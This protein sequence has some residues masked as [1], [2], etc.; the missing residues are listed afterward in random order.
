MRQI[1]RFQTIIFIFSCLIL[2]LSCGNEEIT[3]A[4]EEKPIARVNK[5][6][7]Y[8]SDLKNIVPPEA[9]KK[10]STQLIQNFIDKWIQDE[11]VLE[12]A[13]EN[14]TTEQLNI[15]KQIAE[16]RK[17]LIIYNF[18]TELVSQKLDTIITDKEIETYYNNNKNQF[19]LK[20]NIV[21][22]WYI[23]TK[24][25]TPNAEKVKKWYKS[26]SKKD[27]IA[28]KTF[29]VQSAENYFMDEDNWLLFDELLK[30]IPV[31][32]L[33]PEIFLKANQ[34]IEVEDSLSAYFVNIKAYKIKNSLSPLSFEKENIKNIILNKR[35]LKLIE[36]MKRD[37][38]EKAKKQSKFEIF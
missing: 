37:I 34:Y 6:F 23:K 29:C 10:D 19:T 2:A 16:Y 27:Y 30:E 32:N 31:T 7:L 18:Q 25:K 3:N 38:F 15:E 17:N 11:L 33:N 22:V 26:D 13:Q 36:E 9:S 8:A 1:I 24:K 4:K 35:K 21:K 14:L 12:H 5:T 20:D 28:L